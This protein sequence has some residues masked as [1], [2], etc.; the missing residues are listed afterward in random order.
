MEAVQLRPVTAVT[1]VTSGTSGHRPPSKMLYRVVVMGSSGVG[2]TALINQF[3]YDSFVDDHKPTVEELHRGEYDDVILDILD[4]S[5]TYSFP[6]MRTLS[7]EKADGFVLVYA[8]DDVDSFE[9]VRA[10]R[11]SIARLQ[12]RPSASTGNT[13][14]SSLRPNT[15]AM[16]TRSFKSCC[17]ESIR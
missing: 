8:V 13:A 3:L 2:K 16:S 1:D 14:S 9:E 15:T 7:I 5:G 6:A 4:T 10:G 12:R 17:P 11:R